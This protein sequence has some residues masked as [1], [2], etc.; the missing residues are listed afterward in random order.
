MISHVVLQFLFDC[1]LLNFVSNIS[2]INSVQWHVFYTYD[3]HIL[4]KMDVKESN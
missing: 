4:S 3:D 1:P 2:I